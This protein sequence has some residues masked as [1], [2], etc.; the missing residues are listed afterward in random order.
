MF[1]KARQVDSSVAA[2]ATRLINTYS[3]YMPTV[4][5]IHQRLMSE[6]QSFFVGC[7]IQESTTV[8]AAKG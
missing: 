5:D 8:R 2:E 7:W 4:E 3:R 1:V 6:G